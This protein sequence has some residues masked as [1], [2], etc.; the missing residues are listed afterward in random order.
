MPS[1]AIV[2]K[3]VV[4]CFYKSTN[5]VSG[6]VV[7]FWLEQLGNVPLTLK[8]KSNEE[9]VRRVFESLAFDIAKM[10]C[11]GQGGCPTQGQIEMVKGWLR[12]EGYSAKN[13]REGLESVGESEQQCVDTCSARPPL[14]SIHEY[15]WTTAI[16]N[17]VLNELRHFRGEA[18]LE[19]P[20]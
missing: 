8:G 3:I 10:T 7:R 17:T 11:P 13:I 12:S 9:Q 20:K 6:V 16:A 2:M 4:R 14:P 5:N 1:K 19:N 15:P 18:E